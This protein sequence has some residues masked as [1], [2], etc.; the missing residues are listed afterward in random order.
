VRK[1]GGAADGVAAACGER[2]LACRGKRGWGAN[3]RMT[4]K[5]RTERAV[6][7]GN[8]DNISSFLAVGFYVNSDEDKIYAKL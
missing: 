4:K 2:G 8:Y 6:R 1:D 3:A 5:R 7:G